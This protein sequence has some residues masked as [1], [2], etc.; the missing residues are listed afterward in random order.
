MPTAARPSGTSQL[1][2]ELITKN[3]GVALNLTT[4]VLLLR[5]NFK[6]KLLL[7]HQ[8]QER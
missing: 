1:I 4:L 3:Y 7:V 8:V 6:T 2:K 5:I